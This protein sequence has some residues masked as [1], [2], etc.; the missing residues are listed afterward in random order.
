MREFYMVWVAGTRAPSKC[1]SD[2]QPALDE[3]T[4]LR[5]EDTGREVYVLAPTHRIDG[6]PLTGIKDG[7]SARSQP[8]EPVP[9]RAILKKNRA[10]PPVAPP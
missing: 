1:Y 7:G 10:I 8:V 3:A 6:R 4:R 9:K 2:L 5:Q